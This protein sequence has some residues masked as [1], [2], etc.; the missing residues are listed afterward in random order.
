MIHGFLAASVFMAGSTAEGT[1]Q[2]FRECKDARI[3]KALII[4]PLLVMDV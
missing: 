4:I 2:V 3:T 1:F